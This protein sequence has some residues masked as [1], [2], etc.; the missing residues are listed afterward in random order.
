MCALCLFVMCVYVS[1]RR[2]KC[3]VCIYLTLCICQR[4]VCVCSITLSADADL[5]LQLYDV[6]V[7]LSLNTCIICISYYVDVD[8]IFPNRART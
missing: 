4:L 8:K 6:E 7:C 2:D 5:D 1:Q 3:V